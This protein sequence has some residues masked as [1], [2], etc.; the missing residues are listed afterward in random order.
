MASPRD[1]I[2]VLYRPRET[3]RRVLDGGRDRWAIQIV[4]LATF[5]SALTDT[6]IRHLR[7]VLPDLALGPTIALVALA[8]IVDALCW[9]GLL[10]LIA[11]AVTL[12]GR[13]LD[14]HGE[15]ADVRAA[16][17]WSV[18]PAIW[19]VFLRIPI[20]IYAYRVVPP[21]ADQ[22]RLVLDFIANGGCT[23]A[24]IVLTFELLLYAWVGYMASSTVA[25]ALHFSTWKGLATLAIVAAVPFVIGIAARLALTT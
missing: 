22:R 6:D 16:L 18:V 9:V 21:P 2:T 8:L 20:A 23:F 25:E 15:V 11:L 12:V 4:I 3:M 10:Y 5:C 1:L 17:A 13:R 24:I 14:G 19:C 7:T